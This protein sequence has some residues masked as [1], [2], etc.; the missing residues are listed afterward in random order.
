MATSTESGRPGWGAA[1]VCGAGMAG[2]LTARVLADFFDRVLIVESDI[3]TD[4]PAARRGVPQGPHPHGLLVGGQRIIDEYFPGFVMEMVSHRAPYVCFT[5]ARRQYQ[6]NGW[7]PNPESDLWGVFAS[8]GLLEWV[9]R[10][11][12]LALPNVELYPGR[13]VV[14]MVAASERG[15]VCGV[16]TRSAVGSDELLVTTPADLVVDATGRTSSGPAWLR[17]LGYEPPAETCVN[18]FWGYASR[19]CRMPRDWNPEWSGIVTSP[20]GQ[21]GRTRGAAVY[22]Q[23]AETWLFTLIGCAK[24]Y[25]QRDERAFAEWMASLPAS[26]WADALA[27]AT[28]IS[29]IAVWRQ[30]FN[31]LRHY[32]Q[33]IRQPDGL[34]F[35]GDTVCTLNP[36][37]GQGM[38]VAA[39]GARELRVALLER[40]RSGDGLAGF[41]G[42]FQ[43]R[44]AEA[45]RFSWVISSDADHAIP[46]AE[47]APRPAEDAE[48]GRRWR[49]ALSL[50]NH[51][52]DVAR[53]LAETKMLVRTPDWL[54][55]LDI[56]DRVTQA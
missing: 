9:I 55:Q 29:E 23:E 5:S 16:R 34:V 7:A 14:E 13:R 45:I 35:V 10:R 18:G 36:V 40:S 1:V 51:D 6:V 49:S 20:N 41:P 19:T 24:D 28:P 56:A 33:L 38:T 30:T 27:L 2:L 4:E 39:L 53:L 25:P 48:L 43:D 17:S 12:V 11:R 8:R 21:P 54:Y 52:P 32:D 42:S 31:R 15:A 26:D 37:Y 47:V 3:P 22:R 50:A 46:G 44:L